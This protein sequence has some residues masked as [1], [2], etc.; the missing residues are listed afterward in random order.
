MGD[1]PP[2]TLYRYETLG[3]TMAMGVCAQIGTSWTR[4]DRSTDEHE[5]PFPGQSVAMGV[6]VQGSS[7]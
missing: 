7:R 3:R 5:C 4:P 6:R 2:R 1:T